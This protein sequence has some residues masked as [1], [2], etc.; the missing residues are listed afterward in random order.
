MR[1]NAGAY[2]VA[3]LGALIND[4]RKWL[5]LPAGIVPRGANVVLKLKVWINT[6]PD[7]GICVLSWG[8]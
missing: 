6:N 5:A 2:D 4:R 1:H 7:N 3:E 8:V